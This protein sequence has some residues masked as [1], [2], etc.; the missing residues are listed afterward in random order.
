MG[1][2]H[3]PSAALVRQIPGRLLRLDLL[4]RRLQ[5]PRKPPAHPSALR[6]KLV[7]RTSPPRDAGRKSLDYSYDRH[8]VHPNR[9]RFQGR[10]PDRGNRIQGQDDCAGTDLLRIEPRGDP[11]T[12]PR[13]DNGPDSLRIRVLL[14]ESGPDGRG[15]R[16]QEP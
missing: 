10:R 8:V 7:D 16:A 14:R 6:L 5:L 15:D 13:P 12:A 4:V 1:Q 3:H 9:N 11:R 2:P